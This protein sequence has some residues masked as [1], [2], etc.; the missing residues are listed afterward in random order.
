MINADYENERKQRLQ[1]AARQ[2]REAA[3]PHLSVWVSASAGTGKTRVLSDRVLR[4][5]LQ[6]VDAGKILCLTYTKAAAAEMKSR[7]FERLSEWAIM[8]DADLEKSLYNLLGSEIKNNQDL[9]TNKKTARTCF[10]ELL[11]TPGGIKIQTI[12]SFCQEILKR[13]PLEAEILPYFNIMEDREAEEILHTLQNKMQYE[14]EMAPD[15]PISQALQYLNA[16]LDE[17]TFPLVMKSIAEKRTEIADLLNRYQNSLSLA[18]TI[19]QRLHISAD[20]TPESLIYAFMANIDCDIIKRYLPQWKAGKNKSDK[21]NA[22]AMENM[23]QKKFPPQYFDEYC[24]IFTSRSVAN[25]DLQKSEPEFGA[26]IDAEKKRVTECMQQILRQKLYAAT[27]NVLIVAGEFIRR[28]EDYKYATGKMDYTDLVLITRQLLQHSAM[29]DWVLFKLDG[30]IDHI[31]IDEAQDTSP[32]QWDIIQALCAEFWSGEGLKQNSTVFVV[33]D[34]KQSIFSFQGADPK[35]Y[36]AM[37]QDTQSAESH[38]HKV[39]LEVSFR[40]VPAVLDVVNRIFAAPDMTAG[41]VSRGENVNH[42]AYRAGEFGSVQIWPFLVKPK[43]EIPEDKEKLPLLQLQGTATLKKQMAE[44]IVAEIK[45]LMSKNANSSNPLHYSDFMVLVQR[46]SSIVNEFIRACKSQEIPITGAD[47]LVLSKEIAVQDLLSL[48]KFLLLPEDDLSLAEVLKSPLCGFNDDDLT[49]LCYNRA[50][51]S[52]WQKLLKNATANEKYQNACTMLQN[53]LHKVDYVRPYELYNEVMTILNGRYLMTERMGVEVEDALDEFMSL[54]LSFEKENI[55]TLQGFVD[56]MLQS[57]VEIKR[58]VDRADVDAVRL[59]TVHHSKGLQAPIVFLADAGFVKS[60]T[61]GQRLLLDENAVFYP[62]NKDYYDS[63]CEQILNHEKELALNESKRLLYVALTRAEDR[64]YV[65]GFQ[66]GNGQNIPEDSWYNM[67]RSHLPKDFGKTDEDSGIWEYST[68]EY[69]AKK[70]KNNKRLQLSRQPSED[71]IT[72]SVAEVETLAK[73]YTPSKM[74][75]EDELDSVSPLAETGN[76]YRRGTI[77][78]KLLQ[79]LPQTSGDKAVVAAEFLAHHA[80]DMTISQHKQII[81]E[82][83]NL[84][85]ISEYADIFGASSR[86]EVPVMGVVDGKIISAQLDRLVILP[87]KVIIVDFKT[88]RPAAPTLETTPSAYIKQLTA[89]VE[90]VRHI[91][92]N[93]P[94]EA[95]IL[96]T[97]VPRL[98]RVV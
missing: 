36:D 59:M 29:A 90:L 9:E 45:R 39:D 38:F 22:T 34:R 94:V 26:W 21:T 16:R 15:T 60:I 63:N 52:L 53:L 62:L 1:E 57:D 40:S 47:K 98:M 83:L 30:G 75:D 89:Y 14:A 49:T 88:N 82:V 68:P 97:N 66:S 3:N 96:W 58:E 91:Y 13:F 84:L 35:R 80:P 44:S 74:L 72:E 65:C 76:Y 41:V 78:H 18:T 48:G 50:P 24:Q 10:A 25:A 19:Q 70:A 46:R 12:H 23:L 31:L 86:A 67:C 64:L 27:I 73:P 93:L 77:I 85:N 8:S 51:D 61:Q 87:N 5:L 17:R 55:P 69:V 95:Y 92:P 32:V 28:Y 2:Q 37:S 33:G 6:K 42:I 54:T 81:N 71:W 79:F 11:D 4:M 43:S 56:W 7:I 20:D